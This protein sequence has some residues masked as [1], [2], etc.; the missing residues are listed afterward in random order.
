MSGYP[1]FLGYEAEVQ[2]G[3]G[4]KAEAFAVSIPQRICMQTYF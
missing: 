2:A 1:L 3:L 4:K